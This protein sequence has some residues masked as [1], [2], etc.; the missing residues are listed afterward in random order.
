MNLDREDERH[1][2]ALEAEAWVARRFPAEKQSQAL[3]AALILR[4]IHGKG[5]VTLRMV[6]RRMQS[7]DEHFGLDSEEI[8]RTKVIKQ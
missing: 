4:R 7:Q 3:V 2:G 1:R 8:D 6:E 5:N